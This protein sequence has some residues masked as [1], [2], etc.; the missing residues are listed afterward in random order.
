MGTGFLAGD[1]LADGVEENRRTQ[2]GAEWDSYGDG[3]CM[4]TSRASW[5]TTQSDCETLANT[6]GHIFYSFKARTGRCNTASFCKQGIFARQQSGWETFRKNTI[7]AQSGGPRSKCYNLDSHPN[8]INVQSQAECQDLAVAAQTNIYMYHLGWKKCGLC[9][10]GA[11]YGGDTI[12]DKWR[13]F[14]TPPNACNADSCL[15]GGTCTNGVCTCFTG[16]TGDQ[17]QTPPVVPATF[18]AIPCG[19]TIMNAWPDTSGSGLDD[20]S[21][22]PWWCA[23]NPPVQ[24]G[25]NYPWFMPNN[26]IRELR[27]NVVPQSQCV[28]LCDQESWCRGTTFDLSGGRCYMHDDV[29]KDDNDVPYGLKPWLYQSINNGPFWER[30]AVSRKC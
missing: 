26:G 28:A 1:N 19:E 22:N 6:N 3:A 17:C 15:N 5:G 20:C 11:A 23:L 24:G 14:Y 10:D 16:F 27:N 8:N 29:P 13:V 7:W 30:F 12:S 9:R 25:A 18:G 2:Q 4:S 21:N